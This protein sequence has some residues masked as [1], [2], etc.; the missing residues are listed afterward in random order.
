MKK[1]LVLLI[2]SIFFISSCTFF[3]SAPG[4]Y[5]YGEY[6]VTRTRQGGYAGYLTTVYI[7]DN[8]NPTQ[9]N[10]RHDPQ[11]LENIKVGKNVRESLLTKKELFLHINDENLTGLTTVAGLEFNNL[12]ER[13][14]SIPVRYEENKY[15]CSHNLDN[16][17]GIVKLQLGDETKVFVEDSC[18]VLQG[19]TEKDLVRAADRTIFFL[20]GIM[21]E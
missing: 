11:S 21:E 13:F 1:I 19:Q 7:N 9:I 20:L 8:T 6:E 10:T 3:T 5:K 2:L 18:V 16:R 12:I 14:Y 4:T 15:D 17:I